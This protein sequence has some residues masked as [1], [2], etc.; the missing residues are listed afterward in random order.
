MP[1]GLVCQQ[2]TTTPRLLN[3]EPMTTHGLTRT[4]VRQ[5]EDYEERLESAG[6]ASLKRPLD[7]VA[8]LDNVDNVV[9]RKADILNLV[10]VM[11]RLQ[12]DVS[13]FVRCYII[14]RFEQLPVEAHVF[15]QFPVDARFIPWKLKV[16]YDQAFRVLYRETRTAVRKEVRSQNKNAALRDTLRRF[17]QGRQR[18]RAEE[19]FQ[20]R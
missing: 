3:Q 4:Q 5:C 12:Q 13:M 6:Y 15:E 1:Y 7:K 10:L 9:Q 2:V 18:A 8:P 17:R 20:W 16:V 19:P 11:S 14:W